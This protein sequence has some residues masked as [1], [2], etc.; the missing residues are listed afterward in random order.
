M[1]ILKKCMPDYHRI[2]RE[3][4][5]RNA[6]YVK[7][8]A[9]VKLCAESIGFFGGGERENQMATRA[10]EGVRK[11]SRSLLRL[12]SKLKESGC[13]DIGHATSFT[14]RNS[15]TRATKKG[16]HLLKSRAVETRVEGCVLASLDGDTS[17]DDLDHSSNRV[18]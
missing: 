11:C 3:A 13:T 1:L 12:P 5:E 8:H 14:L 10:F 2:H 15:T 9:R 4:S 6:K 17:R 7:V 16:G 18:M